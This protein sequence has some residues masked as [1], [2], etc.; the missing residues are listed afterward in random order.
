MC[1]R[2]RCAVDINSLS[3]Q[4]QLE[5]GLESP[6]IFVDS[7]GVPLTSAV[8]LKQTWGEMCIRDS[9]TAAETSQTTQGE[10]TQES[11][12]DSAYSEPF[13]IGIAEVQANDR[14]L[15][16]SRCV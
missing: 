2:D 3:S 14:L 6:I 15:Y 1:I 7:Q 12:T 4:A 11:G 13:K 16:T 9:T 5:F 10:T 8:W